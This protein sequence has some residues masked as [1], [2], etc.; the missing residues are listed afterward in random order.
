[1]FVD[2][3]NLTKQNQS[4]MWLKAFSVKLGGTY[5]N[6]RASRGYSAALL[7]KREVPT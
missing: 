7:P 4:E 3:K 2:A 1:M 6:H 5:T